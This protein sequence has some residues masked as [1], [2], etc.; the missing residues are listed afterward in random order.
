MISLIIGVLGV[1]IDLKIIVSCLIS[2]LNY[3]GDLY[4]IND[5]SSVRSAYALWFH[6]RK[7]LNLE[8]NCIV[9][10]TKTYL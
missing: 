8:E 7:K 10:N 6:L 5:I 4:Y 2:F 1:N 9:K 3:D